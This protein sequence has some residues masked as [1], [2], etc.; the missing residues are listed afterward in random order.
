MTRARKA[1]IVEAAVP[2]ISVPKCWLPDLIH[3][4]MATGNFGKMARDAI[5]QATANRRPDDAK[6]YGVMLD[7]VQ[8]YWADRGAGK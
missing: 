8:S 5:A 1:A 2:E 4:Q 7:Q 6:L 3:S